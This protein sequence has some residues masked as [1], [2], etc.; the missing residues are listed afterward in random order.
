[1]ST[2]VIKSIC[3]SL[4]S[5]RP[6]PKVLIRGCMALGNMAYG[7]KELRERMK[8]DGVIPSMEK[9]VAEA[10][11]DDVKQAAQQCIESVN[12]VEV[13]TSAVPFMTYKQPVRTT[14]SAKEL[15]G[16]DAPKKK[17]EL[18]REDRNFLVSGALL[19]K[20]SNHAKP[21][22]RHLSVDP[23]LK[24]IICKDPKKAVK[25]TQKM[26][27]FKMKAIERGRCTPQLVRKRYGKWLAKE[28]C[29]FA[30]I[31]RDRTFDIECVSEKNREE[32]I[33]ALET[34][35]AYAKAVKLAVFG[36]KMIYRSYFD[37]GS[38]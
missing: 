9:I 24:F 36:P 12:R 16:D 18:S 22:T 25:P 21:K 2:D 23:D 34:L 3:M 15:F 38:G 6:R 14:K 17:P 28:E 32:W 33:S 8:A 20:H 27:V 4:S 26:K 30:I 13:A 1:M 37:A 7:S 5:Q 29:S 31:G 10:V 19:V 35:M 11:E